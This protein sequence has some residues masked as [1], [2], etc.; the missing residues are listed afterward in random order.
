M[1]LPAAI[2]SI[3]IE[4]TDIHEFGDL[5]SEALLLDQAGMA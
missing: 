1:W 3:N 2:Q 4:T 5:L